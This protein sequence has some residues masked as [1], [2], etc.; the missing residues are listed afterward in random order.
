MTTKTESKVTIPWED[1]KFKVGATL[2][3][4]AVKDLP[5]IEV[6]VST[7]MTAN[8][9]VLV[10]LIKD[11]SGSYSALPGIDGEAFHP[12]ATATFGVNAETGELV[13]WQM[14]KPAGK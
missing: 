7:Q 6:T 13:Q 14:I 12:Q 1:D 11:E 3:W 4:K 10:Q 9:W 2:T 5:C 8:P